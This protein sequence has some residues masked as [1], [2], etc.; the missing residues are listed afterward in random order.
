MHGQG[1]K[2]GESAR[3]FLSAARGVEAAGRMERSEKV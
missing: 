3:F 2:D 1:A